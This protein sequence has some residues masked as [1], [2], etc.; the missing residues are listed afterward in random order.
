[1]KIL[2][3]SPHPHINLAAPS[4]PGTHIREVIAGFEAQGHRV[5]RFIAGGEKLDSTTKKIDFK[6]RPWKKL[7][8]SV[9]W[10]TLRDIQMV[11]LDRQIEAR[12]TEVIEA[13]KPDF[14]YERSCYGMGAGMRAAKKLGIR[15][16]VEMNAP[17]PEE[18]VQMQGKSLI[19]FLGNTHEKAQ[20]TNAFRTIVVSSAMKNYLIR[21]TNVDP[22]KIVVLANA[23]NPSHIQS[24]PVLEKDIRSRF[25][26]KNTHTV[27]GF[28]GSIFP[29]H[30]VDIMIES[31]STLE[32]ENDNLRMLI[33]GDGEILPDLKRR[34][35]ELKLGNKIHFTGNVVH[36][37]VYDY[38]KIM[39][40]TIMARSNWYGSP[41]KMFEYGAMKKAIIAPRVVPVLDVMQHEIDGLLI[42]ASQAELTQSMR[43]MIDHPEQRNSMAMTFHEKVMREHTW[44]RVAQQI[45]DA[46]Q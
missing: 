1:M 34:V 26:L 37:Q 43:F 44:N 8:P 36:N 40:I 19:Q 39:D 17:Y 11:R 10:E 22:S 33:V 27:F 25:D 30:G 15:Y 18:K 32:K 4:G 3:F 7:I 12:L 21:K 16:V 29:Y 31:F 9:I 42:E 5:V 46:C 2:Y 45:L 24:N 23:V 14:I 6:K 41:V 35:S 38:L 20:V 28:V 13:E